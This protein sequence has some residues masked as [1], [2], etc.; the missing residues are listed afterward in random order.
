VP[1]IIRP[2][3]TQPSQSSTDAKIP[4]KT[5]P[6]PG[7]D[8]AVLKQVEAQLAR[9]VGP[10]AK[11]MVK[12]VATGTKDI[13]A[14][15]A[16]LADNLPS[17]AEK[18]AFLA[19][20]TEVQATLPPAPESRPSAPRTEPGPPGATVPVTPETAEKATR[21]LAAYLGP[22]SR[23]VVKKAMAQA[24]DRRQFYEILADSLPNEADRTRFLQ[25]VGA[26]S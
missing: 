6:P 12:R 26:V 10:V 21:L 19:G 23:F 24:V 1:T 18:E 22:I 8:S 11:V 13:A 17:P 7:W 4:V 20:R 25:D 14:L 3:P 15:Y 2:E 5:L 9:F 16:L